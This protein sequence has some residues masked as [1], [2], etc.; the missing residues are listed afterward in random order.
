[1]C[2]ALMTRSELG[3]GGGLNPQAR[4]ARAKSSTLRRGESPI[5]AEVMEQVGGVMPESPAE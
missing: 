2:S 5:L 1:M 4:C 3:A